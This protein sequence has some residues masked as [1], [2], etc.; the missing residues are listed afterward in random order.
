MGRETLK[1]QFLTKCN[2]GN[3]E[4]SLLK[5]DASHRL[6]ERIIKEDKSTLILMDAPPEKECAKSYLKVANFLTSNNFSAPLVYEQ[7]TENGFLLLEDFGDNLYTKILSQPQKSTE[8]EEQMYEKAIDVLIELHKI[9]T[10][11]LAFE[12]YDET[13]LIKEAKIFVQYYIEIL[14]ND[15]VRKET[16]EEYIVIFKHLLTLADAFSKVVVLRDYHADN[17]MW[18]P[19][20]QDIKKVGILDFQDAVI[21]SPLYD[22]VSLLEDARRDVSPELAEKMKNRYLKAFPLIPKKEFNMAYA[23]LALHRNL[24]IVGVFARLATLHKNNYYLTLLPRVW[25][26]INNGVKHPMLMPI[27]KW[28][29][30]VVPLQMKY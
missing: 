11:S 9:P 15:V 24:K 19:D 21:G 23:I 14:N 25:R 29:N 2:L 10:K 12:A 6:Y 13:K 28:L 20:R 16:L 27:K 8:L 26:H 4:K 1:E 30:K 3:F 7:D 5:K 22:L 18:L 17:L